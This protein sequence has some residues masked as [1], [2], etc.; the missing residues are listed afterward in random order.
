MQKSQGKPRAKLNVISHTSL[1]FSDRAEAGYL[2]AEQLSELR[3]K[4]TVV[5]GIPRGG[6][7]VARALA[8]RIAAEL[9][10]VL[11][12]KLG[13]PGQPELAMG[14]LAED[15]TLFLNRDI[16]RGM[17]LTKRDMAQEKARQMKEIEHRTKLIRTILPK[18]SLRNKIVVVTDDGVATGATMQAAL[19]AVKQE[20]PKKIIA[21]IPVASGDALEKLRPDADEIICLRQPP[22]FYA[23]GQF[24]DRFD[25]VE[26]DEILRILKVE[27]GRKKRSENP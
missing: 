2:L 5:L 17:G 15:G 14:A 26:D 11:A 27:T 16:V 13:A 21:A 25:Q 4:K 3:D 9:D 22:V 18:R 24:Y 8:S 23:V 6:I 12:R 20:N 10:I 19:W 1:P 7:I